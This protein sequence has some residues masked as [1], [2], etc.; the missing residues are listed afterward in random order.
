MKLDFCLEKHHNLRVDKISQIFYDDHKNDE[1][2]LMY[3]YS[4]IN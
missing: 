3:I 1:N 4:R 2:M